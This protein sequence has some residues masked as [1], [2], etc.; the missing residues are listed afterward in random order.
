MPPRRVSDPHV[1][2]L[3]SKIDSGVAARTVGGEFRVALLRLEGVVVEPQRSVLLLV[4]NEGVGSG[5]KGEESGDGHNEAQIAET[6]V[7]RVV[8]R[9]VRDRGPVWHR[10]D[11]PT[12][13]P[14][15]GN[16][17]HIKNVVVKA[18]SF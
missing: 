13:E 17:T 14:R 10:V 7:E 9:A 11:L 5:V 15:H 12:T 16:R 18:N 3:Q 2:Y 8:L 4:A 6:N 1:H